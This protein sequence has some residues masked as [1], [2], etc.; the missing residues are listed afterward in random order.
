MKFSAWYGIAVGIMM[1]AQ[2]VYFITTGQ[3]PELETAQ[4]SI[5]FHLAAEFVT[6]LALVF[7]GFAVLKQ[8]TWGEKILLAALGM[9][10]YSEIASSGYF[11]QSG[12]WALVVM[13]G[14]LIAGALIAIGCLAGKT[15]S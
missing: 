7:G 11:A 1:I 13:F 3:V 9:V 8:K 12:Q 5:G 2:W 10:A 14:V 6:A 15:L 4:W